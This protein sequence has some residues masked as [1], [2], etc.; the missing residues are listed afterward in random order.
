MRGEGKL[1]RIRE[2]FLIVLREM[3]EWAWNG[4]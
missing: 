4:P 1:R 2:D 3:G